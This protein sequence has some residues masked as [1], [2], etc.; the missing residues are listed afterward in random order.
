MRAVLQL[1]VPM[2]YAEQLVEKV[3][4]VCRLIDVHVAMLRAD[5]PHFYMCLAPAINRLTEQLEP[6]AIG[7]APCTQHAVDALF[8]ALAVLWRLARSGFS[9]KPVEHRG[10]LIL[11]LDTD[12]VIYNTGTTAVELLAYPL[13][14]RVTEERRR[15]APQVE[16]IVERIVQKLRGYIGTTTT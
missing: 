8:I 12:I 16:R 13:M 3:R 4:P 14:H 2:D 11:H 1:S 15:L 10:F 7:P 6:I 9:V 5:Y